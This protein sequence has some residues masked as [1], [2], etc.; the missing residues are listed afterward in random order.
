MGALPPN[1]Q[2]IVASVA[3]VAWGFVEYLGDTPMPPYI[4]VYA[5]LC[6]MSGDLI[7][8]DVNFCVGFASELSGGADCVY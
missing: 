2:A 1:P 8:A 7:K 3:F 6:L 5:I 4:V